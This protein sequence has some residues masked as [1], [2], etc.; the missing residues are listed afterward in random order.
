MLKISL[1][2]AAEND[3]LVELG[4]VRVNVEHSESAI[5]TDTNKLQFDVRDA[6]TVVKIVGTGNFLQSDMTTVIPGTEVTITSGN[7]T[8]YFSNG[9]YQL[10]ISSKYTLRRLTL[11]TNVYIEDTQDGVYPALEYLTTGNKK[12]TLSISSLSKSNS[13][14]SCNVGNSSVH[15]NINVFSGKQYFRYLFT[16][17]CKDIVGD[18]GALG[19]C[20]LLE[21]ATLA[22]SKLSGTIEDLGACI[23]LTYLNVVGTD[24]GGSLANLA[25]SM[26]AAGRTSGTLTYADKNGNFSSVTFPYNP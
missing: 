22:N 12:S 20:I 17:N 8:I 15:G 3:N 7:L 26:A 9:N 11:G 14:L 1:P 4:H 5:T 10:D 13:I 21:N 2:E 18:I 19:N 6:G 25:A 16:T 23:K 24:V